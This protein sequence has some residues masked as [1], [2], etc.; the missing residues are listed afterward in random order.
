MI[1]SEFIDKLM[2][3][4]TSISYDFEQVRRAKF[5]LSA[6][7]ELLML[8]AMEAGIDCIDG[9]YV[10][11]SSRD[12]G[13]SARLEDIQWLLSDDSDYVCSFVHICEHFGW[14][15]KAVRKA[16]ILGIG[17]PRQKSGRVRHKKAA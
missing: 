3:V 8:A 17:K 11:G 5:G 15:Y 4:D 16:V 1:P 14:D 12:H 7:E 13:R 9:V 2:A 10:A 6:P